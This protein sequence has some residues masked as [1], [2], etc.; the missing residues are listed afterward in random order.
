MLITWTDL[1]GKD[2][3]KKANNSLTQNVKKAWDVHFYVYITTMGDNLSLFT[4]INIIW[5][6]LLLYN[7]ALINIIGKFLFVWP[8]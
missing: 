2:C 6:L 7:K 5:L 1:F 3:F 4:A 8:L